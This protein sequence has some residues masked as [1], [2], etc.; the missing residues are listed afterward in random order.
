MAKTNSKRAQLDGNNFTDAA[1][2]GWKLPGTF[3]DIPR[4]GLYLRVEW[5]IRDGKPTAQGLVKVGSTWKATDES[6]WTKEDVTKTWVFR[7]RSRATGKLKEMGLGTVLDLGLAEAR[8]VADEQ[9]RLVKAFK[10]PITT[11]KATREKMTA[12]D[13]KRISLEG[14]AMLYWHQRDRQGDFKSIKDADQ[15]INPLKNHVFPKIG[16]VDVM[17]L[18]RDHMITV[19]RP[20]WKRREEGGIPETASRVRSRLEKVLDWCKVER[21]LTGDNVAAW[22]GNLEFSLGKSPRKQDQEHHPALPFREISTFMAD[23]TQ[24]EA[25]A[26]RALEFLILTATRTSETLLAK[27]EEFDTDRMIWTIPGGKNSRMKLKKEHFVTLAPRAA[28]ILKEMKK[29]KTGPFVFPGGAK[30]GALSS[31]AMTALLDRMHAARKK[32]HGKEWCDPMGELV[33]PHGF[34]STFRDWCGEESGF[35]D[36]R[37]FEHAMA[38]Q[39]KDAAEAAYSR[40]TMIEKRRPLMDAWARYCAT[41]KTDK[42]NVIPIRAA[43]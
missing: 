16:K 25:V 24:R 27:W 43:Q 17:S 10:D 31:G 15:W 21:G 36:Q 8:E 29:I 9:R 23:L 26:A 39:L 2:K 42:D 5:R 33:V 20:I 37:L 40:G 4:K 19:L 11:R 41:I 35:K 30:S 22:K 6:T 7:W 38:H 1:V 13:K 12:E 14:A 34:R 32:E 3:C 28:D 18:T